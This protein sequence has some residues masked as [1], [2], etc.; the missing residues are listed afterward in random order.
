VGSNPARD[1]NVYRLFLRIQV[2]AT[3]QSLAL[4]GVLNV[5]QQGCGTQRNERPRN[6]LACRGIQEEGKEVLR[7]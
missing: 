5:H 3:G 6:A 4:G 1:M 2:V 7:L